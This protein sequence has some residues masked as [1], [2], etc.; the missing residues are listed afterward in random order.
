MGFCS[1]ILIFVNEIGMLFDVGHFF[2]IKLIFYLTFPSIFNVAW[3]SVQ[4]S[5]MSLVPSISS[6]RSR[7]DQLNSLRNSF[8]FGANFTVLFLALIYFRLLSNALK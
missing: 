7:R 5:H 2:S 3:A 6:S 1:F 8:T 4:V